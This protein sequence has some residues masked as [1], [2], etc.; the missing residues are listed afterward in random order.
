MKLLREV[1]TEIKPKTADIM[2]E[3][4]VFL[5]LL[6]E[7]LAKDKV[8][9]KAI[10]GGSVAKDTFLAGD[11][12]CDVYAQFDKS[13]KDKDISKIL[14]KSLKKAFKN[15]IKLHGSR[16]YYQ[17]KNNINF[18]IV[19]TLKITNHEDAENITDCSY[20][21]AKWVKKHPK[22]LDEIRLTKAF[23]KANN[24]YGA[25]SY[26]KGFS[27]HV[28]D[29]LTIN[30][31]GFL[32]LLKDSGKWKYNQVIDPKSYHKG[33]AV[34]NLNK[35]KTQSAIIL[36]D[37]IDPFRNAA[38]ALGKEKFETF[39]KQAK[40]FLKSPKKSFFIKEEISL[41][42][43]KKKHKNKAMITI[44]I[45]PKTGK[46]DVVGAKLLKSFNYIVKQL[47]KHEFELITEGWAWDKKKK[48]TFYFILPKTILDKTI[49][50]T[51][52][53][54]DKKEFVKVFKKKYKNTFT[55]NKKLYAKDKRSYRTP[56]E[57]IKDLIKD[58]YITE[59]VAKVNK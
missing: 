19:P 50:R 35:S 51:G 44:N 17:I 45:T 26:I 49:I 42:K 12:D 18:E 4:K 7:Q 1:L 14:G 56:E 32:K 36:I 53:P 46:E 54:T 20:L 57:L 24:L 39:K 59:K 41:D 48:A 8:K 21:H 40:A 3:I 47:K 11:Y 16:D 38:A 22:M 23:C 58:K 31:G 37:P 9:A 33:K 15:V 27:G 52:P 10:I 29:I 6:N 43:I 55:K 30:S 13:Y 5:A 25:E 34:F 2:D 28:V